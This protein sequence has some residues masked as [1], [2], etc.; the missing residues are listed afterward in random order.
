MTEQYIKPCPFC[1]GENLSMHHFANKYCIA[2]Q[3]CNSQGPESLT[4]ERAIIDWNIREPDE[5]GLFHNPVHIERGKSRA[6][7][8]VKIKLKKEK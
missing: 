1:G 8:T 7:K 5:W 2:C 3:D 4:R 6:V